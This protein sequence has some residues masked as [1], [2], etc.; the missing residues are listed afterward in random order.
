MA[1]NAAPLSFIHTFIFLNDRGAMKY[2]WIKLK[3][4]LGEK[5]EFEDCEV[6][7]AFGKVIVYF[8]APLGVV[9]KE[10]LRRNLIS[11]EKLV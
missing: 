5:Y 10:F 9:K 7:E 2:K 6:S 3:D 8:Q 1:V 4:I 11:I